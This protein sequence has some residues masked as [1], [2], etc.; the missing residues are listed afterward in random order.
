MHNRHATGG[1]D[2]TG[3]QGRE[4][5]RS[6]GEDPNRVAASLRHPAAC[7][8]VGMNISEMAYTGIQT[9]LKHGNMD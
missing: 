9:W 4:A 8:V 5:G 2:A 6:K 3:M 7:F 1:W